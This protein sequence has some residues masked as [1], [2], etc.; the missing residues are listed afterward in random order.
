MI[1]EKIRN[2]YINKKEKIII[3]YE[4]NLLFI[5]CIYNI[6]FGIDNFNMY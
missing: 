3:I 4:S 5:N 1:D 2:L 6:F